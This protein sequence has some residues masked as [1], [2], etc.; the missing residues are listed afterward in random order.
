VA[1]HPEHAA[2]E[3][4][5]EADRAGTDDCHIRA[6]T[7]ACHRLSRGL[8]PVYHGGMT[9]PVQGRRTRCGAPPERNKRSP[10][11][12]ATAFDIDLPDETATAG[13]A[14]R[15]ARRARRG[16]I[17]GLMG[18]LGSGKT[19]FARAFIRAL[20]SGHEEVPSPT[21]TLVEVYGFPGH[22]PVWHFDLYRLTAPEQA[23]E[24]GIE[25]AWSDGISLV[26]WPE[27]LGPLLPAEHLLLRLVAAQQAQAR[28]AK[29]TASSDWA[30]R[31][32]G[33][34]RG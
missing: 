7:F 32:E 22:P 6:M 3:N 19:T 5:E 15:L 16:D 25:D 30:P 2:L 34:G 26:E 17:I 9:L 8:L 11:S 12:A 20:G 33:V 1:A 31:L 13:F 23:Y 24:L 4:G 10:V 18:D 14:Q 28:V 21:F 29:L 27:R